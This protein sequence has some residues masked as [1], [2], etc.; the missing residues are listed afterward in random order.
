VEKK[1]LLP[2]KL[3]ILTITLIRNK[4][5]LQNNLVTNHST[6]LNLWLK[7]IMRRLSVESSDSYNFSV[8]TTTSKWNISS[9]NKSTM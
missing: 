9:D 5:R 3:K 8:K 6:S 1:D 7:S 2:T 4:I